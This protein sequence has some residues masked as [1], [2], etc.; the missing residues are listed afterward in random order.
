MRQRLER[1]AVSANFVLALRG[2]EMAV[3]RALQTPDSVPSRR[4]SGGFHHGAGGSGRLIGR[5][6]ARIGGH[7][8]RFLAPVEPG[9]LLLPVL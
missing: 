7:M 4:D 8:E 6:M 5:G 2:D 9:N 1:F 3:S